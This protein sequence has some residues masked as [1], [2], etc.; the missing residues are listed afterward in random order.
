VKAQ[1][2]K[3]SRPQLARDS[4]RQDSELPNVETGSARIH[5]PKHDLTRSSVRSFRA[6]PTASTL[7]PI[8]VRAAPV[9]TLTR[10]RANDPRFSFSLDYSGI[11]SIYL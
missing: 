11:A 8:P 9:S 10:R 1:N 5:D 6:D 2:D 4:W 3:L 7:G